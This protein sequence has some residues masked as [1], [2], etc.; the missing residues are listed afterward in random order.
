ME[1]TGRV[2]K[3][4]KIFFVFI[5]VGILLLSIPIRIMHLEITEGTEL[6]KKSSNYGADRKEVRP[7]RGSIYD[8]NQNLL[9]TSLPI[10]DIGCDPKNIKDE[11]VE[12]HIDSLSIKIFEKFPK[13]FP[14]PKAFKK[15]YLKIRQ[16]N[17]QYMMISKGVSYTD[18][19]EIKNFPIFNK[20]RF[21]G[22]FVSTKKETRVKPFNALAQRSLGYLVEGEKPNVGLEGSYNRQLTGET[23]FMMMQRISGSMYKPIPSRNNQ[24]PIDGADIVTYLDI[25][26]QDL[27]HNALLKQ[28]EKYKALNGSMILMEVKTGAIK[29][30]VNL[31]RGSDGVYRET[32]NYAVGAAKEPGSTFKLF[33][34]MV[35]MEDGHI[36]TNDMIETGNGEHVF[37]GQKMRDSHRGGFGTISVKEAF[38]KSSNIAIAKIVEK[39]YRSNPQDFVDK[40]ARLGVNQKIGVDIPGEPIPTIKNEGDKGWSLVSLPWMAYGYEVALSPIQILSYYNAIANHGELVKPQLVKEVVRAGRIIETF[41]KK[42]LNSSICTEETLGK[43]KSMMKGVVAKG[44]TASNIASEQFTSGGKTGT[45]QTDYWNGQRAYISSFAGFFPYDNPKYSCIVVVEKPDTKIGF[46]GNVVAAPAFAEVRNSLFSEKSID[47]EPQDD[48]DYQK[49]PEQNIVFAE[50]LE[51]ILDELDIDN[52]IVEQHQGWLNM[53]GSE[54]RLMVENHFIEE[55]AVPN[56]IGMNLMDALFLLE[57]IGL[58]VSYSGIGKIKSQSLA[59]GKIPKKGDLIKLELE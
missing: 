40:L 8:L 50:D 59:E 13:R 29:A 31:R 42:V 28:V 23:G 58:K 41:P 19:V 55:S 46:Y 2:V 18:V 33:S 17:G 37:Y 52:N 5:A 11:L 15:K 24:E 9:V 34:Y 35:A 22:G 57:N 25:R 38:E 47:L 7:I 21:K 36:D 16:R 54:D 14:S 43:L 1:Q 26:M 48:I 53:K 45:C 4:T 30:M 10:Y 12:D 32:R 49:M 56:V 6:R 20:G 39:H 27:C 3:E 44:G 51:P